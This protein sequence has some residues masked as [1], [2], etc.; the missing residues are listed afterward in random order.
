MEKQTIDTL[1]S[2]ETDDL[3]TVAIPL[4]RVWIS[5]ACYQI[6][7]VMIVPNSV[8]SPSFLPT[9]LPALPILTRKGIKCSDLPTGWTSLLPGNSSLHLAALL[10]FSSM[11]G[12]LATSSMA[13]SKGRL[14][15]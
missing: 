15:G 9:S 6:Y 12:I 3:P 2:L 4:A 8:H 1:Q 11:A 5:V 14:L 7:E 13:S 10:H